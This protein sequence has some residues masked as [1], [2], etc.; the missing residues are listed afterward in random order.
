MVFEWITDV[1]SSAVNGLPR[2]LSACLIASGWLRR[3]KAGFRLVLGSG[4]CTGSSPLKLSGLRCKRLRGASESK[5]VTGVPLI[6]LLA[7]L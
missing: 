5:L 1:C 7:D 2:S 4:A 3:F 6:M